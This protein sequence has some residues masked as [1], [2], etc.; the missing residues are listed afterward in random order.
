MRMFS[1][2]L[3]S[4]AFSTTVCAAPPKA[5]VDGR[6]IREVI[7]EISSDAYEGRGPATPAEDKTIA[8][9]SQQ[10]QAHG[11]K[12]GTAT[13]WY[14]DVPTVTITANPAMKLHVE[15]K[16]KAFD[17]DY[18]TDVVL[19]TKRQEKHIEI[20][21]T[22]L[23]Y[24]G[25][26][27]KAPEWGWNDYAGLDVKGKIVI[28]EVNDPGFATGDP[29][30]FNGRTMTYYGRWTYKFE[31]AAR[32]GAAGA[33]IV[34]ET[35]AAAY[36]WTVV[37]SSNTGAKR[38]IDRDTKGMDR[39]SVEGWMT[40]NAAVKIFTA[41]GQDYAALKKSASQHGFKAIPLSVQASVAF[42]NTIATS[43]SHNVIGILPGT[44]HSD[45]YFL[46]T[47]HWDHL[48][49]CPPVNGDDICNGAVDNASGIGGLMALA[50][51]FAHSK[52]K[53]ERSVVF[54]ALTLEESGLLGSE[55]YGTHPTFPLAKTVAGIN[56]D[57]L[58]MIGPARDMIVTG[59]GKSEIEPIFGKYVS[60]AGRT[61]SPEDHPEAGHF[62]R[63]DHFSFA[64]VGVPM[65]DANGGLSIIGAPARY[66]KQQNEEYTAQRYHQP[67]DEFNEDM[68]FMSAAK[69]LDLFYKV[70][71]EL[72][73]T[74]AW[75]NWYKSAEF[76]ASRDASRP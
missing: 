18:S 74:R 69:D 35:Q 52:K 47:A 56:M 25:Y 54:I 44:K 45:E 55:W 26:G 46:Y 63:S 19:W 70:G 67:S 21:A 24:V 3:L 16:G 41:A 14:Q 8:Y 51:A 38:D 12:P 2:A 15:G 31:E 49:H 48:G 28:I 32:Q 57:S 34:H 5:I 23:V 40:G 33:I 6:I 11:L 30:L 61:I 58:Q 10:F 22:D 42:D 59:A 4:L 17:L 50:D 9:I 64:K 73:T 72:T 37:Q 75:P 65:L 13:G 36:P 62:F 60:Q 43:K 68:D 71:L 39:A 27:I 7:K 29:K 76:R 1:V 20:K 66:G 53:P